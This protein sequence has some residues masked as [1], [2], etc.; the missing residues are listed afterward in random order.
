[1]GFEICTY[2]RASYGSLNI[3]V[4]NASQQ[5]MCKTFTDID[6]NTVEHVFRSNILQ[7]FAMTKYALTYMKK[8][9]T[10]VSPYSFSLVLCTDY[11]I[12]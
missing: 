5:F 12:Y 7:M 4:N 11:L 9:D 2:S 6:L 1:M 3:L 8:G 10:Y